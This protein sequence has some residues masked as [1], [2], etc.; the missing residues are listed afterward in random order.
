ML[1]AAERLKFAV[2]F[3]PLDLDRLRPGDWMNLRDDLGQF[4]FGAREQRTQTWEK[5]AAVMKRSPLMKT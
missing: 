4:I 5:L 3:A 2:Q 1:F